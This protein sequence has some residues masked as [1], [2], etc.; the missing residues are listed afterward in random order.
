MPE[1]T[2]QVRWRS[3]ARTRTR[4]HS[5]RIDALVMTSAAISAG[6]SPGTGPG[7]VHDKEEG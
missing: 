5:L 3:R 7:R 2:L 4:L 1:H 6:L